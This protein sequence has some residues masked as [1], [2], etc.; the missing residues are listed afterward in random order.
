MALRLRGDR[1]L[2]AAMHEAEDGD[3]YLGD[4]IHHMLSVETGALVT[5]PMTLPPGFGLGGHAAHGEWWWRG[6][7]P[8]DAVIDDWHRFRLPEGG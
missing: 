2:C 7:A 1:I 5:E 3:I 6:E 8:D 4:G